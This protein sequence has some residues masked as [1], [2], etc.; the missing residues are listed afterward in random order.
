MATREE[1]DLLSRTCADY[2]QDV[3]A[4]PAT[5]DGLI[6]NPGATAAPGWAGPYLPGVVTDNLTNKPGYLVDSWSRPYT[7]SANGDVLRITSAGD[8]AEANSGDDLWIELDVTWIRRAQTLTRLEIVNR[9][10][11][12]YNSLYLTSDPLPL[13]YIAMRKKL[14]AAKVLPDDASYAGDAW[15]LGFVAN[16][17][18]KLPVVKVDSPKLNASLG[19]PPGSG[20]TGGGQPG[21]NGNGNG[22]GKAPGN[23]NGN[24]KAPGNGNGN[25][26][27]P[28][29]SKN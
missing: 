7:L 19:A 2:F 27:A 22:N 8:D 25:G 13:D 3:G 11:G 16:P 26:K 15:G 5:L 12:A 1:L 29:N 10:I 9:A 21:N 24:G 14:V 23:G 4:F 6:V 28:G 18:G 20:G 17:A